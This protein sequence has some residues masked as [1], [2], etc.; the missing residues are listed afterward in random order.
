M[1]KLLLLSALLSSL[2]FTANLSTEVFAGQK[3]EKTA[4]Q[5]KQVKTK[6]ADNEIKLEEVLQQS[7]E[8]A[9]KIIAELKFQSGAVS[10]KDGLATIKLPDNFRYL[11]PA[12]AKKVLV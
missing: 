2:T 7:Q 4:K 11:N 5:P 8:K 9:K 1:Q 10:I 3:K 6:S 12:D